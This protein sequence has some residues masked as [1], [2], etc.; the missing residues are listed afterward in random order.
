MKFKF[1][2]KLP[3]LKEPFVDI[4]EAGTLE[5]ATKQHERD[6]SIYLPK[7]YKEIS[8]ITMNELPPSKYDPIKVGETR[9]VGSA[10]GQGVS[11]Q[12]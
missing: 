11:L 1:S 8:V 3:H 9:L 10:S 2:V 12:P 6:A 4:Y 7:N 5:E